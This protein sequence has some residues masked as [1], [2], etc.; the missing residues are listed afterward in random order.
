MKITFNIGLG[1]TV[2]DTVS[3][4]EGIVDACLLRINGAKQYSL[5]PKSDDKLRRPEGWLI[6]EEQLEVLEK[7]GETFEVDFRFPPRSKVIDTITGFKGTVIS[8]MYYLNGCTSY[9]ILPKTNKSGKYPERINLDENI[10]E[11]RKQ[12]KE[13][14]KS[15][16]KKSDKKPSNGAAQQISRPQ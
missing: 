11:F 5:Q 10:L 16:E 4:I 8:C 14:K 2:L 6:D 7:K 12:S 3:G 1:S 15:K 13:K 9:L